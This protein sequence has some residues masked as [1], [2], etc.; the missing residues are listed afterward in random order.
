M[1]TPPKK[2]KKIKKKKEKE[3]EVTKKEYFV[4]MLATVG[5]SG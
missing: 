3:K 2:I 5:N 4:T 1:E